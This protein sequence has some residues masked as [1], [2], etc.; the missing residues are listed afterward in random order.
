MKVLYKQKVSE[1]YVK[2]SLEIETELIEVEIPDSKVY[3]MIAKHYNVDAN[4]IRNIILDFDINDEIIYELFE[5][6][7]IKLT[8]EEL[9]YVD[10]KSR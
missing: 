7:I 4:T 3:E 1:Y 9:E 5:E 8:E 6:E 10:S 2:D